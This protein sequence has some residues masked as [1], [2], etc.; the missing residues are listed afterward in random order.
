M[1]TNELQSPELDYWL[2]VMLGYDTRMA[3]GGVT[4]RSKENGTP[5]SWNF[6]PTKYLGEIGNP[7]F[8]VIERVEQRD[9]KWRAR[10][11]GVR[12]YSTGDDYRIAVCRAFVRLKAGKTVPEISDHESKNA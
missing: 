12:E 9:G 11:I 4:I 8:D 10:C 5:I 2:G 3:P 1:L 6:K 7:V